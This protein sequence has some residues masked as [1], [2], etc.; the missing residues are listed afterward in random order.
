MRGWELSTNFIEN[1][2]DLGHNRDIHV[3]P[4]ASRSRSRR[5]L[6][7]A[8]SSSSSEK[9]IDAGDIGLRIRFVNKVERDVVVG[10]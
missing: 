2:D 3:R 6:Q 8:A 5:H 10:I 7:P 1:D 4:T 9:Q